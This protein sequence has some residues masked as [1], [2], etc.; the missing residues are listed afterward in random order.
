MYEFV[1][2]HAEDDFY[3][4]IQSQKLSAI[5]THEKHNPIEEN[6]NAM[7]IILYTLG[8]AALANRQH[9]VQ[10]NPFPPTLK[11]GGSP[12]LNKTRKVYL[13]LG[14]VL[15]SLLSLL[16]PLALPPVRAF[17]SALCF[18][19]SSCFALTRAHASALTPAL[20]LAYAFVL[21]MFL[22]LLLHLLLLLLLLRKSLMQIGC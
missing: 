18:C 17:A 9:P 12:P 11:G 14:G 5:G 7:F 10:P 22:P 1:Q 2:M 20:S 15:L 8:T 21:L 3:Q 19:S 16:R 13:L 4:P 6:V